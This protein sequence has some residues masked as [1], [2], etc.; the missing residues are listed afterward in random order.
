MPWFSR[1]VMMFSSLLN[2]AKKETLTPSLFQIGET[3]VFRTFY[4]HCKELAWKEI[5]ENSVS[6]KDTFLR[7]WSFSTTHIFVGV[8]ADVLRRWQRECG[9][10]YCFGIYGILSHFWDFS[11]R[12]NLSSCNFVLVWIWQDSS[13]NFNP[14]IYGQYFHALFKQMSARWVCQLENYSNSIQTLFDLFSGFWRN[15]QTRE[16]FEKI[17]QTLR[18]FW[19]QMT[20]VKILEEIPQGDPKICQTIPKKQL[21]NAFESKGTRPSVK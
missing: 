13:L 2:A 9:N 4:T 7:F 21:K 3:H 1:G 19:W 16:L 8:R 20:D 12:E 10:L 11:A 15:C 18:I 6:K 5:F 17:F 14:S